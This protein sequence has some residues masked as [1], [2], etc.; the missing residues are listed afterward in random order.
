MGIFKK[1]ILTE[2]RNT[3]IADVNELLVGY[4]INDEKWYDDSAKKQYEN[5]VKEVDPKDL[6]RATGHAEIMAKEFL[7]YARQKG[8]GKVSK[9]YW[10]AR[11]GSMTKLTGVDVD[12]RK[13]PTDTLIKFS[14]G[15]SDGWLGLSAKST[16]GKGEIGFKNPGAGT[17][18]KKLNIDLV[19]TYK[20]ILEKTINDLDL[21][22]STKQRKSF[23]RA[24]NEIKSKT[25][26]I[27]T[28]LMSDLR[29]KLFTKLDS[30]DNSDLLDYFLDDWLDANVMYPP[31]VKVTGKGSKK[32][33]SASLVEPTE[34]EK[35]EALKSLDFALEKVGNESIGIKAKGKK[36]FKMR[37]KFESEKMA[38]SMKL[39]GESW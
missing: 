23:I 39:S 38:S 37:F 5:R 36:I 3:L 25:T 8:Y 31:Y 35:N 24:N 13:N 12:Q 7:K 21:P 1:Y 28:D 17:V 27:G 34:N 22:K 19:N 16:K 20:Q 4:Y 29:D 32:P 33:F 18:D 6:E 11:A 15:P 2:S 14:T 30:M 10:T 26:K 9:V